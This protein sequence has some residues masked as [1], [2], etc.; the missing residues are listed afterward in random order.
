MSGRP[1]LSP[2]PREEGRSKSRGRRGSR[3]TDISTGNPRFGKDSSNISGDSERRTVP[4]GEVFKPVPPMSRR[5]MPRPPSR[6]KA[7]RGPRPPSED[8][9]E[10]VIAQA[11]RDGRILSNKPD[12]SRRAKLK[13]KGLFDDDDSNEDHFDPRNLRDID[14]DEEIRK[15]E[16]LPLA[17]WL[18]AK[19]I[20][21]RVM[22]A[23]IALFLLWSTTLSFIIN[24]YFDLVFPAKKFSQLTQDGL[25]FFDFVDEQRVLY[26]LAAD[27]QF[28]ICSSAF[29]EANDDELARAEGNAAD[30]E[31]RLD[32]YEEARSTSKQR[33]NDTL[34]VLVDFVGGGGVLTSVLNQGVSLNSCPTVRL[35][36]QQQVASSS[37][38]ATFTNF[39]LDSNFAIDG[40]V[41]QL[42]AQDAFTTQF[43]ADQ[44]AALAALNEQLTAEYEEK[45]KA[46][47]EEL[48]AGLADFKG[49]MT[50]DCGIGES[51]QGL[52]NGSVDLVNRD[53]EEM[54]LGDNITDESVATFLESYNNVL[55]IIEGFND[56]VIEP[57]QFPLN[58]EPPVPPPEILF[59]DNLFDEGRIP[60]DVA[61]FSELFFQEL[62][63][64]I[65]NGTI[66]ADQAATGF[67]ESSDDFTIENIEPYEPPT[68]D[69]SPAQTFADTLQEDAEDF[70]NSIEG[71]SQGVGSAE[72]LFIEPSELSTNF[73]EIVDA[74]VSIFP[75]RAFDFFSYPASVFNDITLNINFAIDVAIYLDIAF[76]VVRT[77]MTIMRYWNVSRL[78]KP[79]GDVRVDEVKGRQFGVKKTAAQKNIAL[80]THP[81]LV[82]GIA[83]VFIISFVTLL[84]KLYEPFYIEYRGGCVENGPVEIN[85]GLNNGTMIYRNLF[86]ASFNFA[87][88]PGDVVAT[89]S[90]DSLNVR[91]ETTC[92]DN[93]ENTA[94]VFD[95]QVNLFSAIV[96]DYDNTLSLRNELVT[97]IDFNDLDNTVD[98]DTQN[99]IQDPSFFVDME[100]MLDGVYN[101]S[102]LPLCS[103]QAEDPNVPDFEFRTHE[104]A[105][106]AELWLHSTFFSVLMIFITYVMLYVFRKMFM[107]ALVR[108]FWREVNPYEFAVLAS[109]TRD[110]S[111]LDPSSVTEH[112]YQ[113][114]DAIALAVHKALKK[115]ERSSKW[116][117]VAALSLNIPW[118][119]GAIYLRSGLY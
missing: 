78:G 67:E 8:F 83:L 112:G 109:C 32:E 88:G 106:D 82:N 42:R 70:K 25:D 85:Q 80:L 27:I 90:V 114:Q 108:I 58:F 96:A 34:N 56:G 60:E 54:L 53:F 73:T 77:Y 5:F 14:Y 19:K 22:V 72:D 103:V 48:T 57:L 1:G 51:F 84:W 20:P 117:M 55:N 50:N 63:N 30:N 3:N 33:V 98:S 81:F 16:D 97:C 4:I 46:I 61:Q 9:E 69:E 115:W 119:F 15:I 2:I 66:A 11:V 74:V 36:V 93:F 79:P 37:A 18:W 91:R 39:E 17:E 100:E 28:D 107:T 71:I 38:S 99:I 105:C 86:T 24:I 110:G 65:N 21:G 52:V 26:S 111:H 92:Q 10:A 95:N 43:W 47:M 64:A 44:E 62:E 76:R 89:S 59:G 41:E 23:F 7:K 35:F 102:V 101:C 116:Y 94:E 87:V 6:S 31:L 113:L 118:I 29:N 13:N 12:L 40:L 45:T 104:I 49:C 68:V 75:D